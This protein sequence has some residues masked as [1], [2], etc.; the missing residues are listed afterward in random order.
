WRKPSCADRESRAAL[1]CGRWHADGGSSCGRLFFLFD[2]AHE[3]VFHRRRDGFEHRYRNPG[4]I[5]RRANPRNRTIRVSHR[6]VQAAAEYGY[7]QNVV[8]AV[9]LR[10]T[11]EQIRRFEIQQMADTE[12]PLQLGGRT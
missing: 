10:E 7:I 6:D 4:A 9:N 12:R 8:S 5:E 1:P 2:Q 11:F 3:N